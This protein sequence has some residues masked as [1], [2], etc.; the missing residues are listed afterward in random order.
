[1]G[2]ERGQE[3][4]FLLCPAGPAVSLRKSVFLAF[5]LGH[6]N[7]P[8]SLGIIDLYCLQITFSFN[9]VTENNILIHILQLSKLRLK[10]VVMCPVSPNFK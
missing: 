6:S 10:R 4:S 3:T 8:V 2:R 7:I 9:L 1:M 5:T